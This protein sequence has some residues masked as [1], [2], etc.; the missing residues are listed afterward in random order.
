MSHSNIVGGSTAKRVI[1]CPGSVAL[2]QKVPPKPSSKYAD[3]G[4]LLHNVMAEMLG[5][6]KE[7]R[8]VL[9]MEYNGIKLTGELID[10]KVRPA[11]DAINEIDPDAQ[12]EFAVEQTV[13]FGDLIPGVFGSCDLIGRIGD[14]AIILDWKFGDGVAVEAEENSQLLFYT[15]A[16][17]RTPAL[18]WVFKDAKEIECI[19][20]QP[21]KIKRWVTSFDRVRL[22]ERELTYAVKQS[23]KPDAPL[24][25]GDHCRWCAAKPICPLMTGA[26]DRAM[27][28]QIKE[29]DVTQL[30]DML[31]RADVLEDWISDLR[32]LALQVLESGNPV[33]GYK[34]VQKRATRQWKD[35]ES[36]KQALLKHLSMTDVMETY[37]IS[38]AQAEK[39]LKKLKLPLPDDQIIS[40]SSGT[41]LAPESDPRPAVL[42]IGQQLTAALSKLV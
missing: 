25:I 35:E 30:G 16:A 13:S 6:D 29:L 12:L 23:A 42:Q 31:Q 10:E 2:C 26:V 32:A 19:I 28:T 3:E 39:K 21:P 7:L 9:D 17:I 8:H 18:E 1:N 15:A 36:A 41:T 27:Q 34:L 20:V 37:L 40:V 38:P 22:F 4:T 11:L 24:K 14:R 5:S 33:P